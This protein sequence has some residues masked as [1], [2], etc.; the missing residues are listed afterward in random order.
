MASDATP[1]TASH[2]MIC[3]GE[4]SAEVL[5][6]CVDD[7]CGRRVVVS[8]SRPRLTVI[9]RGDFWVRHSGSVGGLAM[10]DVAAA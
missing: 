9:D 4:N 6:V 3:E 8:K 5:F 1:S 7:S 2:D 10:G